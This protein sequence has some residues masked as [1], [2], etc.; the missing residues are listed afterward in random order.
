MH[1]VAN[2]AEEISVDQITDAHNYCLMV[3]VFSNTR[4][5][6]CEVIRKNIDIIQT[7]DL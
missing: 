4:R 7:D 1:Q 2:E 3:A 5:N 6:H